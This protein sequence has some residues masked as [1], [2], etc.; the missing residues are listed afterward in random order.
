VGVDMSDLAFA[1][2]CEDPAVGEAVVYQ[3]ARSLSTVE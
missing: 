1:M 2:R 3:C